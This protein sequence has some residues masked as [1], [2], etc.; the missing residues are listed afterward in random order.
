MVIVIVIPMVIATLVLLVLDVVLPLSLPLGFARDR[1]LDLGRRPRRGTEQ[2]D[3]A[4]EQLSH[5]SSMLGRDREDVGESQRERVGQRG[6]TLH[7]IDLVHGQHDGF[8]GAP[9]HRDHIVVHAGQTLRRV[10][11][12]NQDIR[13]LDGTQGLDSHGPQDAVRRRVEPA[14]VDDAETPTRPV[15]DP[16]APIASHPWHVLDQGRTTSHQP[17]EQRRLAD[18]RSPHQR[19]QRTRGIGGAAGCHVAFHRW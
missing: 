19:H 4:I 2:L 9:Q 3:Q 14:R 17:V 12:Q 18:I 1:A 16:I 15:D 7:G 5:P 13:F 10:H 8:A 11:H 6:F